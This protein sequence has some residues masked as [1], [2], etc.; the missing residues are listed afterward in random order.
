MHVVSRFIGL[1]VPAGALQGF[2]QRTRRTLGVFAPTLETVRLTFLHDDRAAA[3][4]RRRCT[5]RLTVGGPGPALVVR[6]A[7]ATPWGAF[8]I[9]LSRS[10]RRLREEL[11]FDRVSA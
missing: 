9:A 11:S 1:D 10:A 6:G 3:E 7:A 5:M 2:E 4:E 8:A